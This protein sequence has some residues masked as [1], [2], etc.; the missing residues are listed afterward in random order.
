MID[1]EVNGPNERRDAET[2]QLLEDWL[3]R[4]RR[5]T[6]VD[7]RDIYPACGGEDRACAPIPV[8]DRARTDFLWQRS[9]FQLDGSGTGKIE[10]A[11]IDYIL[12]YWMARF[13][14]VVE[15]PPPDQ[16]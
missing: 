13:Y 1:R 11:G 12:P 4:P 10:G 2:R 8:S 15:P 14:G 7:L 5:D 9:P 6:P 3:L 16:D